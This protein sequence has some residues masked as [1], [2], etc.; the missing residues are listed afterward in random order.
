MIDHTN[1]YHPPLLPMPDVPIPNHYGAYLQKRKHDVHTGVDLYASDGAAVYAIES[2]E[3]G[4]V[5]ICA[6]GI[7]LSPFLF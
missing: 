1:F 7:S 3:V 4:S 2:G 6:V 5:V